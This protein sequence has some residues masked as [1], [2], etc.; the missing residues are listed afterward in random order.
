MGYTPWP[1]A[2]RNDG[3]AIAAMSCGIASIP[4]VIFCLL[5]LIVGIVGFVLGLVSLSR[6]SKSQG[7]LEGRGMA[8]TGVICGA[9][10]L[11]LSLLYLV[12]V[13]AVN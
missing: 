10:G 13:F 1:Q 9:V 11:G 6:I 3:L 8:L 12:L 7:A 4:L 2:P 5:G